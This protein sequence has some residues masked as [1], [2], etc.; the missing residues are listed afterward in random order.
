MATMKAGKKEE[1][2]RNLAADDLISRTVS[3]GTHQ[4][5]VTGKRKVC[6]IHVISILPNCEK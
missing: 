6:D 4:V 2:T 3:S 5:R 1:K